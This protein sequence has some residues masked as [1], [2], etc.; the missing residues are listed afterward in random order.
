VKIEKL[1]IIDA[2]VL[3]KIL[4]IGSLTGIVELL[5][6]DGMTFDTIEGPFSYTN[7]VFET[8]NFRAVGAIGL[9][10]TGKVDKENDKLDGFGTV[11]PS[12]TLNSMLGNIPILGQLLVGRK[13][14]GI[15]GFSYKLQGTASNPKVIVNPVSALAPGILRRMF[16]EPWTDAGSTDP[17]PDPGT[18]NPDEAP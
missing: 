16:F 4:T 6:N 1:R 15:F 10:F 17:N 8:K 2:P 13:G 12:Y 5:Q 3:G 7:G 14:E 18:E 9:T 11:I